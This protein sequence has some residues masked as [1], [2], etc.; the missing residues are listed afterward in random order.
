MGT[1]TLRK[2]WPTVSGGVDS[3]V[4]HYATKVVLACRRPA[5]LTAALMAVACGVLPSRSDRILR[6]LRESPRSTNVI[7]ARGLRDEGMKEVGRFDVLQGINFSWGWEDVDCEITDKGIEYLVEVGGDDLLTL[8]F[9]GCPGV[10]D[11]GVSLLAS[12]PLL[13]GLFLAR[14]TGI[15]DDALRSIADMPGVVR[16]DLRGCPGITDEGVREL[17]RRDNWL[18][19]RLGGCDSVSM[20]TAEELWRRCPNAMI[21]KDDEGWLQTI[22]LEHSLFGQRAEL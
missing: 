5:L 11:Y 6:E 18:V 16:L 8:D 12:F 10:S 9:G 17:F 14:C 19:V 22:S 21:S 7:V 4:G 13:Q 2:G 3:A 1:R 15:T 20:E